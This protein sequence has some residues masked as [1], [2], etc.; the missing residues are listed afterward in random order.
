MMMSMVNNA[1]MINQED[2]S[3]C[4]C[5]APESIEQSSKHDFFR[6][7]E[8]AI[9]LFMK[10]TQDTLE[11]KSKKQKYWKS[12]EA[13][14][15]SDSFSWEND[16]VDIRS[17]ISMKKVS[18]KKSF[19]RC[20][21][22]HTHTCMKGSTVYQLNNGPDGLFIISD[23]LCCAEQIYWAKTALEVYSA[24]EHTN[25]TN[26]AKLQNESESSS[27]QKHDPSSFDNLWLR[28]VDEN[29]NFA[30][31]NKLR[32]SCLGYHYGK[33]NIIDFYN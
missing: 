15:T 16:V 32:W 26:L 13:L 30:S 11:N 29:N 19:D 5:A 25:L 17:K 22:T 6:R 18:L 2:E 1:S 27:E 21:S 3:T 8:R 10:N 12:D 28:S 33:L 23:V 24:V 7:K 14:A 4:P 9:K 20:C 31:F